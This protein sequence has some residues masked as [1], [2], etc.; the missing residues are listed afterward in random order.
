[1]TSKAA[2]L[3]DWLASERPTSRRQ[4]FMGRVY[5]GCRDFSRNRLAMLG[6]LIV[7]GLILVAIFADVLAPY[8]AYT[9][10][11]RTTRLLPPSWAHRRHRWRW[12]RTRPRA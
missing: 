2:S 5:H 3:R 7:L 1:M 12:S 8:S 11:L 6:L 10:D 4:A 9:G